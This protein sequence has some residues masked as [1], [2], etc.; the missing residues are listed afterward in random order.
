MNWIGF[1][2]VQD[3]D[4][5]II[6]VMHLVNKI[7][8][9]GSLAE[10]IEWLKVRSYLPKEGRDYSIVP[11]EISCG[12]WSATWYGVKSSGDERGPDSS[13]ISE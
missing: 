7:M 13:A 1:G 12:E 11:M 10:A 9:T 2:D 5:P 3:T 4:V 6:K 8:E